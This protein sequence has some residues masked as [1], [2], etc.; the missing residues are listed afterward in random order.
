[1]GRDIEDLELLG[2]KEYQQ[3]YLNLKIVLN[4]KRKQCKTMSSNKFSNKQNIL[5][6]FFLI[7]MFQIRL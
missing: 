4:N 1:V 6:Y 3:K 5:L 2:G 7:P